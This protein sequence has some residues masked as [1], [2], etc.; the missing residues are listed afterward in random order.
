MGSCIKQCWDDNARYFFLLSPSLCFAVP[1]TVAP[2]LLL[3]SGGK[4]MAD[5]YVRHRTA[6]SFLTVTRRS[7][8]SDLFEERPFTLRRLASR[9]PSP[10]GSPVRRLRALQRGPMRVISGLLS[11]RALEGGGAGD[12][13]MLAAPMHSSLE[14]RH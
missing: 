11:E 6:L 1:R 2:H 8:L 14:R 10:I 9:A 12:D 3:L 7:G 4:R 5:G 13:G